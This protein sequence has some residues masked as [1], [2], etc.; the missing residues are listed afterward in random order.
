M[1][2]VLPHGVREN[3]PRDRTAGIKTIP[4]ANLGNN[5]HKNIQHFFHERET[6]YPCIITKL[7]AFTIAY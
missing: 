6:K 4:H 3:V 2:V 1:T 5:C 7:F